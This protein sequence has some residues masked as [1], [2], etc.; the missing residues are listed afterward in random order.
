VEAIET[1]KA[2][3]RGDWK[4]A[5]DH[6]KNVGQSAFHGLVANPAQTAT[7]MAGHIIGKPKETQNFV[8]NTVPNAE[9]QGINSAGKAVNKLAGNENFQKI[10]QFFQGKGVAGEK[11]AG[12]MAGLFAESGMNPNARNKSSGAYGIGQWLGNRKKKLMSMFGPHPGLEQQLE[13]LW[14]ELSGGDPGGK[15]V[16]GAHGSSATLDAYVKRFMRPAPGR[17]TMGDL[18]RGQAWLKMHPD[19][20]KQVNLNQKTEI[21]V[22]GGG[23]P[24]MTAQ[25]VASQQD[26]VNGNMV[27]W[28]KNAAS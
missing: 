17:E 5:G 8:Q 16:L 22:Y 12:I 4:G 19:A 15:A 14:S 3:A 2:A 9:Q 10:M 20:G 18:G 6:L 13:F 26:R 24:N 23:D 25:A 1:A 11:I 21:N 7:N 27:R 28:N